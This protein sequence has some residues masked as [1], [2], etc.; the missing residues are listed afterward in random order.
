MKKR[1]LT[2]LF[3]TTLSLS[4]AACG[5]DKAKD[6]DTR[7]ENDADEN[8]NATDDV[9]DNSEEDSSTE[10]TELSLD[11]LEQYLL[12]QGVLTGEKTETVASMIGAEAGF[13]Y[14]DNNAEIYEYNVESDEYK[15][16]VN[17]G[18]VE[19]EG[20]GFSISAAAINDRFVLIE[21]IDGTI[22]QAI[23]DAFNSYK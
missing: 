12:E 6:N 1:F 8:D 17:D 15:A 4:L 7:V 16:L 19:I 13:R 5:N 10:K 3:A 2:L 20:M 14:E 23:L 9:T 18:S 22:D 11:G 21:P